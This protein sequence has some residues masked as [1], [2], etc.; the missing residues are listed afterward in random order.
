MSNNYEILNMDQRSD[1][2][3]QLRSNCITGT[4]AKYLLQDGLAQ[5]L[6][7]VKELYEYSLKHPYTGKAAQRGLDL[8][9]IARNLLNK[10]LSAEKGYE[11]VKF[12]EVGFVKRTDVE[13]VGCSPDGCYIEDGKIKYNCEIKCFMEEHHL[14]CSG[15]PDLPIEIQI[16]WCLFVTGAEACFF[17]NYNPDMLDP[18]QTKDGRA[19]PDQVFF[20]SKVL[21]DAEY[22]EAFNRALGK[23]S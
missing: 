20:V 9:P 19:H 5:G 21:P 22:F 18:T 12:E 1:E 14:A 17:V 8:E 2:W 23:K 16:Q 13:N 4:T 10:R 6:K 15:K 7:K 3:H 11:D